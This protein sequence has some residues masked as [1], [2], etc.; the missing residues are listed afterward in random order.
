M[1]NPF[2][3]GALGIVYLVLVVWAL[4]DLFTSHRSGCS[5]FVWLCFIIVAPILGSIVYLLSEKSQR[6]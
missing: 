4:W 2:G 6:R 1:E 3:Y 5:V